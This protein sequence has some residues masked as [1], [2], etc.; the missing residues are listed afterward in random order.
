[1]LDVQS[2]AQNV[3]IDG[4]EEK[5]DV[6]TKVDL[7]QII[8]KMLPYFKS[9]NIKQIRRLGKLRGKKP[10]PILVSLADLNCIDNLISK[11]A[12]IKKGTENGQFWINR[13]QSESGKRSHGLV[14]A[15]FKF[16]LFFF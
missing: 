2:R 8:N 15:C 1:M 9:E 13:D 5:S 6:E 12:D 4:L 7:M 16:F 14:K 10:R 11:A 3:I